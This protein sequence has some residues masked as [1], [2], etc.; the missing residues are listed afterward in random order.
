MTAYILV[1]VACDKIT[2][3]TRCGRFELVEEA[4]SRSIARLMLAEEGWTTT[5]AQTTT[6]SGR[7]LR[8]RPTPGEPTPR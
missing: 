8:Q 1:K 4:D 3:K 5:D 2:G 7:A 6:R